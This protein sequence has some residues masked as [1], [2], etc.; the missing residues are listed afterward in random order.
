MERIAIIR[1]NG[2]G[3]F[4][5]A[6]VPLCNYFVE[7]QPEVELH[8]FM[9][10]KN[11]PLVKYF[12]PTA[13]VHEFEPG[14][15]YFSCLKMALNCRK[16]FFDKGIAPI[17]EYPKLNNLFLW[18]LG[19]EKRKGIRK[20][21]FK[22]ENILLTEVFDPLPETHVAL[23]CI[24]I[25][26]PAIDKVDPRWFPKIVYPKNRFVDSTIKLLV[27]VSNNR[28]TS[29]L[30][31][32]K[33]ANVLCE[34]NKIK[35]IDVLIS[36]LEKDL[37]KAKELKALLPSNSSIHVSKTLDE[38]IDLISRASLFLLGDGGTGHLAGA[39]DLPGVS[40]YGK[41][42]VTEW[43]VLSEKVI[44]LHDPSDVN[45]IDNKSIIRSLLEQLNKNF[46]K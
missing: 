7:V 25:D 27:E 9:E 1:R 29:Q 40:L 13:I 22:L 4:V 39:L 20:N 26:N 5:C 38:F 35:S 3:D 16:L 36:T 12:L 37:D 17:P 15:K 18:L 6:T 10:R 30:N 34:V 28:E 2:L 43:A 41:T 33:L 21:I 19:A 8:L 44:H 11:S 32:H 46:P 14:N 42:S 45:L 31:I 23:N 24:K